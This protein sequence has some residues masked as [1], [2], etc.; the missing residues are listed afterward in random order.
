MRHDI[1]SHNILEHDNS[2]DKYI[3]PAQNTATHVFF[4]EIKFGELT[5]TK[6]MQKR[7]P[8]PF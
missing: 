5:K 2:S 7:L 8:L 1:S 3:F 6:A 4:L